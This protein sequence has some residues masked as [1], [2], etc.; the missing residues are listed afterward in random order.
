MDRHAAFVHHMLMSMG[1]SR[2]DSEDAMQECFVSAWSNAAAFRGE[3][4][5]RSWLASIA[6]NALRRSH[7]RRI[8]EPRSFESLETLGE[9]AG[10]G[11]A[12]PLILERLA[13]RDS[14]ERALDRLSDEERE[15]VVLRDL[16]ELDGRETADALGLSLAA[17]K[18]R[19]HRGRLK[20][21]AS[22]R[23]GEVDG[24]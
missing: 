10:W 6:R 7:R 21:M 12:S 5:A 1:A 17:M 24:G 22:L 19:L 15:V 14:L 18:S 8:G 2:E 20:M 4:S 9:D 23:T 11:S 13:T 3:G 16:L